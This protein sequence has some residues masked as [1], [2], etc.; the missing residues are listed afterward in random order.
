MKLL[1]FAQLGLAADRL[2]IRIIFLAQVLSCLRCFTSSSSA[3][4][5]SQEHNTVVTK[6]Q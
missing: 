5:H 4:V 1:E 2:P 6:K 3:I